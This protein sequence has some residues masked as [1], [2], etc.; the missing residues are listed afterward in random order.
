MVDKRG[1][2]KEEEEATNAQWNGIRP[3]ARKVTAATV[4]TRRAISFSTVWENE[5]TQLWTEF[6]ALKQ[7]AVP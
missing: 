4:G 2:E 1:G 6:L 5:D 3:E 7:R